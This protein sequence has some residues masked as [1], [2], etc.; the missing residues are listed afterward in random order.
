MNTKRHNS[1]LIIAA[2][3]CLIGIFGI[4]TIRNRTT[5]STQDPVT[6]NVSLY[7]Y[8]PDYDAFE[9]TVSE[10]WKEKHPEVELNFTDWDCYSKQVPDDLDVFVFDTLSLD[11]FAGKGCLLALSLK[12]CRLS[13][14]KC[15]SE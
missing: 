14:Q 9:K 6:L 7:K 13:G 3:L 4:L 1:Y 5:G 2:L 12:I 11:A 8:I 10:C 15:T